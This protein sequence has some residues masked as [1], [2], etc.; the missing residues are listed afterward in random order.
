MHPIWNRRIA[1]LLLALS[2]FIAGCSGEKSTATVSGTVKLNGRPQTTG[3][4]NLLSKTGSA[5][6][7]VLGEGGTFTIDTPLEATEF[8]AYLGAPVPVQQAPGAKPPPAAKFNVLPRHM[9]PQMS[10]V[11]VTLKPGSNEGIEIDFKD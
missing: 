1:A 6:T 2:P 4:I 7:A 3:S 11:T 9:D 10:K 8:A 5:A